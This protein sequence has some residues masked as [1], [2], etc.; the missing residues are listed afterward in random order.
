MRRGRLH[1]IAKMFWV[2]LWRPGPWENSIGRSPRRVR[3]IRQ[4]APPSPASYAAYARWQAGL[5]C[6]SC[7]P[8]WRPSLGW[9][10]NSTLSF[11]ASYGKPGATLLAHESAAANV[12]ASSVKPPA[13]AT[14]AQEPVEQEATAQNTESSTA[15]RSEAHNTPPEQLVV[16]PQ[17]APA[18]NVGASVAG[19]TAADFARTPVAS[20]DAQLQP[21]RLIY[22]VMPEYPRA[23]WRAGAQGTIVLQARIARNGHISSLRAVSLSCDPD[24]SAM[25]FIKAAEHAIY[26]WRYEP[27]RLKGRAV[28]SETQVRV[29]FTPRHT[30]GVQQSVEQSER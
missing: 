11:P 1:V 9:I 15:M 28:G 6:S 30:A 26:Q 22:R 10:R 2:Q 21:G 19:K 13:S 23:A 8:S 18:R 3:N 14:Q 20:G 5:L 12:P 7:S 17:P 29:V 24:S 4:G 27:A 16:P 25:Q